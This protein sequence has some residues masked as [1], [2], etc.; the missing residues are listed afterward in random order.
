VHGYAAFERV[1]QAEIR[2]GRPPIARD[3]FDRAV[4][5]SDEPAVMDDVCRAALTA[6]FGA[7]LCDR[8]AD[9]R[10]VWSQTTFYVFDPDSWG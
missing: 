3:R 10:E 8:L 2:T 7:R 5:A 6:S 4:D 1:V 9:V